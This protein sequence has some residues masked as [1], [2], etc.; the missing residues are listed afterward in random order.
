M[1]YFTFVQGC[2]DSKLEA[3]A[4]TGAHVPEAFRDSI[5]CQ[6]ECFSNGWHSPLILTITEEM[7]II[8]PVLQMKKLRLREVKWLHSHIAGEAVS[9]I[10]PAPFI[11]LYCVS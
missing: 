7:D 5:S 2:K 3:E 11:I 10:C 1:V 8:A 9:Q 4:M 6:T